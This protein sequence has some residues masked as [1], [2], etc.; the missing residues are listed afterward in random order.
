MSATAREIVMSRRPEGAPS[1]S[2]FAV[3]T[4]PL[5]EPGPGEVQVRNQWLSLDPY[6]RL[7]LTGLPG[8]HPPLQPG[9]TLDGGAVGEVVVSQAAELPVGTPVFSAH[10]GW[11]DAYVARADELRP[12]DP[13]LG[14]VQY[15]LGIF[16]LTGITACAGIEDVLDPKPEQVLFVSGAAGAVGSVAVQLAKRRGAFVIGSAGSV[17]KGRWLRDELGA[18]A[19]I[20]YRR[21]DL[22]ARLPECAPSGIDLYFDNVGGDHLEATMDCMNVGGHIAL[23]GSIAQYDS[24]NYRAGPANFFTA[25]EKGLTL[26]GFNAGLYAH[27]APAYIALLAERLQAGELLWR[28]TVVRGFDQLIPAFCDMLS[29][30]NTGKMLVRLD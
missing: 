30:A 20:D 18:D 12:L 19:F 4:K 29:G 7:Y 22:R 23:C 25:I 21:E 17:E 9:E 3:E 15:H 13:A 10:H 16:G 11:R 6:M 26:T 5:P 8:A 2:D 1:Q 28:E 27:R 14:P 24:D